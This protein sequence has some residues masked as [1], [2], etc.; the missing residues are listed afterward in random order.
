[1]TQ[2]AACT[3][4]TPSNSGQRLHPT[5]YRGCW[6][7]VSRCWFPPYRPVSS[8][9]KGVYTP[10]GVVLH[11]ASLGQ[12]CAHCRRFL[13]AAPRRDLGRSQSQCGWS[14]SQTS[15]GSSPWWAL[16]PPT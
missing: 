16:T 15:Y 6:H 7:V 2:R 4:F 13:T 8:G 5:Y 9:G 10:K 14:S 3:R 1:V 11:A 12:A